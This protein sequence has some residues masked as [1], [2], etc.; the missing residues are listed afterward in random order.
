MPR[1]IWHMDRLDSL[2][3]A[4][5]GLVVTEGVS[6]PSLRAVARA[7]GMSPAGVINHFGSAE[8]LWGRLA[9]RWRDDRRSRFELSFVV[10]DPQR[11]LAQTSD[12]VLDQA[13][14]FALM[15]VGRG[16]AG[17]AQE[18]ADLRSAE[19]DHLAR[20]HPGLDQA[21]LDVLVAVVEGLRFAMSVPEDAVPIPRAHAAL[22]RFLSRFVP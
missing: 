11:H 13:F 18:M 17:V 16:H 4:M 20:G 15:E 21:D 14:D 22:E 6:G 8:E 2:V 12:G 10:A 5:F 3:V 9:R 7:A 1:L 19:R